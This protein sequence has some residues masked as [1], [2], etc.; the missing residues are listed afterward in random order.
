MD[1]F[2]YTR[3]CLTFLNLLTLSCLDKM[4]ENY[5]SS[6]IRVTEDRHY[7][8]YFQD[9]PDIQ[10]DKSINYSYNSNART[11]TDDKLL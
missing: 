2:G 1:G 5:N 4:T 6:G 8:T 3:D 9:V 7:G 10:G 11:V